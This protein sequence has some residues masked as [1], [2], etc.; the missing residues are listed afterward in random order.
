MEPVLEIDLGETLGDRDI[1]GMEAR[2]IL[3]ILF[4]G[5]P[6]K[7]GFYGIKLF[8][9]GVFAFSRAIIF[10]RIGVFEHFSCDSNV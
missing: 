6:V 1:S 3:G 8:F 5:F 10:L 2:T 9:C 7:N 4:E